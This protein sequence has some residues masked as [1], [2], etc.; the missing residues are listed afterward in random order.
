MPAPA[1]YASDDAD[2]SLLAQPLHFEFSGRS[3]PNRF[4]KSAMTEKISSWDNTDLSKRGIPTR[5]LANLYRRWGEADIGLVLSGNIIIDAE[6]LEDVGN[7]IIPRD[8]PFSGERFEAFKAVGSAGTKHG[9]LLIGQVSHA[10][11]QVADSI[12]KHP[13]S[14]SDIQLQGEMMGKTFA[15]PR[16]ATQED[17]DN[18]VE[19]FT[20]AAEYLEKAGW[21]G[22]ELHGAHGYLLSQFLSPTTNLR[23]DK[24]GGSLENRAQIIVEIAQKIRQR[25]KPNF[26]LGIKL[27]S[28]EFQDKGLQAE[29]A[30]T[31]ASI[32]EKNAFDFIELSG[33]TYEHMAFKYT[34]ES[35]LKREAFFAEF[36][37]LIAP[38]L[39]KT[40]V[41]L[42]GGF[43]T[44]GGMVA[45]LQSVQGVGL[46]R[47]FAQE[48]RLAKDILQGKVKAAIE[49]AYSPDDFASSFG[50]ADLHIKQISRDQEPLDV[51]TEANLKILHE[52]QGKWFQS[53]SGPD[54]DK[55][56]GMINLLNATPMPYGPQVA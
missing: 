32:L 3:A 53:L 55:Q 39:T 51:S 35:T 48:P 2:V 56:Y 27:N 1:R 31:V 12:Q 20:H 4:L 52:T 28:V 38:V 41:Y 19:G 34:K 29:E 17:I 9:N 30:R 36:A 16:A 54:G 13:I 23:T 24:Y 6:N 26:I 50:A 14:A 7:A 25:T 18:V 15:K 37:D 40:K 44:V 42:T 49:P 46:A 21:D 47:A 43:K 8:A 11:R 33:G 5:E 22:I 45:A 10:G